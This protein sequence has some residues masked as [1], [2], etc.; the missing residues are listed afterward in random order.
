MRTS[1]FT[2]V[3][4]MI[5]ALLATLAVASALTLIARG[6][7]AHRI[8]ESRARLE[9][10][11]RTALDL[12]AFEVR[13]AGYLGPLAPGSPV[14]G[15]TPVGS[16]APDGLGVGGTCVD[17]LAID[18]AEPIDGADDRYGAASGLGV[19][20]PPSPN[21]RA[22]AGSD[23]LVLRRVSAEAGPPD[24]GR[25]QLEATLR[26]G[27]LFADG[28]R[29]LSESSAVH[30]VETSV[31]YVSADTTDTPGFPS[32]RRKRLVGGTTPAFQDEELVSGVA[33]LQ[34]ELGVDDISDG[35]DATDAYVA[36]DAV[37][38]GMR[39]RSARLWVLVQSD[40]P[41]PSAMML[42]ALEYAGRRIDATQ[43]RRPRLLA[44][45]TIELRNPVPGP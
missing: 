39:V 5:A 43:S 6:R 28:A 10:T 3:E 18:L 35:D 30:D 13:M 41:E 36:L 7:S 32:L 26:T 4:V 27:R 31:F 22:A 37:P 25:L 21:G 15:A 40:L 38:A 34:V 20:C 44:S 45:R 24:A 29:T 1:G 19:G 9:E 42:P 16:P 11:A 12:L 8:T 14:M 2:M 23:T 17:S 33:D